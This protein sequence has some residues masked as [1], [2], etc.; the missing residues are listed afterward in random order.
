[1]QQPS[2]LT[3]PLIEDLAHQGKL[4]ICQA[5]SLLQIR[6]PP[7]MAIAKVHVLF[8]GCGQCMLIDS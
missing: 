5:E 6:Q 2:C 4:A 7:D 1:M 8:V 3:L